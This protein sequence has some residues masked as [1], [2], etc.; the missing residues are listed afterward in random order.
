MTLE[1]SS[2]S[3]YSESVEKYKEEQ[4]SRQKILRTALGYNTVFDSMLEENN[5]F[6]RSSV[7]AKEPMSCFCLLLVMQNYNT[8]PEMGVACGSLAILP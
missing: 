6:L 7:S 5:F 1:V 3:Y 4:S 8:S 2:L